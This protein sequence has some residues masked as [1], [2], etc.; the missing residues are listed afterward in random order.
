MLKRRRF[1]QTLSLSAR[2]V[3]DVEH[4]KA[5]LAMTPPGPERDHLVKRIRQNETAA[6]IDQWLTS[7]GL[8]PPQEVKSL[9][10]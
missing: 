8:Q 3:Q 2:L 9:G 6:H 10:K 1:K 4:L 5:Q 7:P